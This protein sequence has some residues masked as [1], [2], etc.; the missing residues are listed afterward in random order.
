MADPHFARNSNCGIYASGEWEAW[1]FA[2]WMPGANRYRSFWD[3]MDEGYRRHIL[4]DDS[5]LPS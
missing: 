2:P 4:E 5:S 1:Y 3:L